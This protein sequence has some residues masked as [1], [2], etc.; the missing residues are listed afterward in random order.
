M[1]ARPPPRWSLGHYVK[2][3][4]EARTPVPDKEQ[5]AKEFADVK[6]ELRAAKTQIKE[7]ALAGR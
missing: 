5:Q 3:A 1:L 2:H 7:L 4:R 6:K